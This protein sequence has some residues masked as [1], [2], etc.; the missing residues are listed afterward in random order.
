MVYTDYQNVQYFLTSKVWNPP[1]IRWA[2]W[3]VNFNCKF[4]YCPGSRGGKPDAISRRPEYRLDEGAM[5]R[6]QIIL[7]SEHFEVS[8]CHRKDKIQVSLVEEKKRTIN[9]LRIKRLQQNAIIPTKGSRMAVGHDI[10]ARKDGT[11]PAQRQMLGDTGMATGLPKGTYG[12][13][14]ARSG[15]AS[16]H[17]IVVGGGVIDADYTGEIK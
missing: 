5:Y 3:V 2:Q 15:M 13:L 17:R 7:K 12:R 14:V 6:E 4:L 9:R 11:I 10:H 16:K 8:L 1:K